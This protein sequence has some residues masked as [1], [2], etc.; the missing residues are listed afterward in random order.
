VNTDEVPRARA[1]NV[2]MILKDMIQMSGST[3][4][5]IM[6]SKGRTAGAAAIIMLPGPMGQRMT[7]MICG[8]WGGTGR[9][10]GSRV[11]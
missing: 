7:G 11:V 3:L 8:D 2:W 9:G 1:P 6:S 4:N 5:A 10:G